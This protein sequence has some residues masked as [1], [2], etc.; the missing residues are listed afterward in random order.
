MEHVQETLKMV[1]KP[2]V[3]GRFSLTQTQTHPL[4]TTKSGRTLVPRETAFL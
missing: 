1:V 4:K 2:I 3:S